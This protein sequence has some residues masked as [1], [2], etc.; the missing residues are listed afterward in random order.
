MP[1]RGLAGRTP[2][3]SYSDIL[4]MGNDGSGLPASGVMSVC[5]GAGNQSTLKLGQTQASLNFGGGLLRNAIVQGG[6]DA[7]SS[8]TISNGHN[9]SLNLFTTKNMVVEMTEKNAGSTLCTNC[10]TGNGTTAG[11]NVINMTFAPSLT[12]AAAELGYTPS[13]GGKSSVTF[14]IPSA[15]ISN[16]CRFIFSSSSG[17]VHGQFDTCINPTTVRFVVYDIYTIPVG[18]SYKFVI[19]QAMVV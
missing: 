11:I 14:V 4:Q 1:Y 7:Y 10:C 8:S 17:T 9:I 13:V 15:T 16:L 6:C 18:G 2:A 19:K 12:L 5:D 3:S